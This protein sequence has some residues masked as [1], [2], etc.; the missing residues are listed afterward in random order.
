MMNNADCDGESS[1]ASGS[2]QNGNAK[3]PA[4]ERD[5]SDKSV[6]ANEPAIGERKQKKTKDVDRI[7]VPDWDLIASS[8]FGGATPLMQYL[9]HSELETLI[10]WATHV[11]LP[12]RTTSCVNPLLAP[13][14]NA[15]LRPGELQ[16]IHNAMTEF[17][18]NNKE[19][20]AN[21]QSLYREF[22]QS[23][24][25][26]LGICL[27]ETMTAALLP[28]AQAH[29]RRCRS[30][31]DTEKL[32]TELTLPPEEAILKL[33]PRDWEENVNTGL[34]TARPATRA[35]P[36]K[37]V[38]DND[39]STSNQQQAQQDA[40]HRWLH[41]HDIDPDYFDKNRETYALLLGQHI[42]PKSNAQ[43]KTT[44]TKAPSTTTAPPPTTTT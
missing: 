1:S 38:V 35:Q 8:E 7:Q 25:V 3:R 26:A 14:S 19:E 10:G 36:S 27:E 44:A 6:A 18:T 33:R 39:A 11:S 2:E 15:P 40:L 12:H 32:Q 23:A 22:D 17:I 4:P 24:L 31:A 13:S 43:T 9:S 20:D 30:I 21:F 5:A 37:E 28:A 41:S 16:I 42:V 34:A 29:V